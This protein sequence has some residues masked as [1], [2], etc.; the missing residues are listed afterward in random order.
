MRTQFRVKIEVNIGSFG[1]KLN[2]TYPK[3]SFKKEDVAKES[4]NNALN[5]NIPTLRSLPNQIS[6][7]QTFF[8]KK[9][10]IQSR[11]KSSN[12]LIF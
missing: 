1:Y 10:L 4:Q 8:E 7:Y 9:I 6:K 11:K 3:I 5:F 12:G 2:S